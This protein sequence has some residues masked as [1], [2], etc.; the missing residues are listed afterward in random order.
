MNIWFE[1]EPELATTPKEAPPTDTG[2]V[3]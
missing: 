2:S 3:T 1:D